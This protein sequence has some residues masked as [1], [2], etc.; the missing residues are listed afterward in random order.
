M[1]K[2][3]I[4]RTCVTCFLCTGVHGSK[5]NLPL[6]S[7]DPS[8]VNSILWRALQSKLYHQDFQETDHLK[9]ILLHCW[10]R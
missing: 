10:V 6:R 1:L 9:C 2:M 8:L 4:H 5:K 3:T 7:L